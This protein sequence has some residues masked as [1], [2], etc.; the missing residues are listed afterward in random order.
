MNGPLEAR[1]MQQE[2]GEIREPFESQSLTP[3]CRNTGSHSLVQIGD[4][5]TSIGFVI[6]NSS[7]RTRAY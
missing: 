6:G 4:R 3:L 5:Q 2:G 1:V 7:I